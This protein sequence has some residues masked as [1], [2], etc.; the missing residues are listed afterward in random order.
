MDVFRLPAAILV[1]A[2]AAGS[3][4]FSFSLFAASSGNARLVSGAFLLVSLFSAIFIAT[5]VYYFVAS[6][7]LGKNKRAPKTFPSVAV[8]VP[9]CNEGTETIGRTLSS[10]RKMRYEGK[11]AFYLLD[12]STDGKA[13]E[14]LAETCKKLGVIRV[15]RGTREGYKGGA[16]NNFLKTAKEEFIA[17]FDFDEVLLNPDF[18]METMGHFEDEKTAFVQTNKECSRKGAFEQASSMTA[19][20]FFNTIQPVNSRNGVAV[21]T[22]SCAVMRASALNAV[23][24]FPNVLVEDVGISFVLGVNGWKGQHVSE[25]YACGS[26]TS[27]FPDFLAKH[28]RYIFGSTQLF[29]LYISNLRKI[30]LAKQPEFLIMLFGLHYVSLAQLFAALL[31]LA[32]PLFMVPDAAFWAVFLYMFSNLFAIIALSLSLYGVFLG[33]IYAYLLNFSILLPRI[34]S[35]FSAAL[36]AKRMFNQGKEGLLGQ[37]PEII[38][39][40][41]FLVSGIAL[42]L[43]GQAYGSLLAWW[44][45]LFFSKLFFTL[46]YSY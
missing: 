27:D 16:L 38:I 12:D 34:S 43:S 35:S 45:L 14:E 13:K 10:L 26:P 3:L 41:A 24:G 39:G 7:G 32:L 22:G 5:A 23:G 4:F 46:F 42:L 21:F 9:C 1:L 33:G 20:V 8:I 11:L 28:K 18:L 2:L 17:I 19:E 37:F 44:S 36:G 25:S 29:P 15:T 40:I 6:S 30:P 31:C